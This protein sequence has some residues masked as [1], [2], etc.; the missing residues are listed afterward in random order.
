MERYPI[1]LNVPSLPN[2]RWSVPGWKTAFTELTPSF[3]ERNSVWTIRID[4]DWL[5]VA[6]TPPIAISPVYFRSFDETNIYGVIEYL[7]M[8]HEKVTTVRLHTVGSARR[9]LGRLSPKKYPPST[10]EDDWEVL[11][12]FVREGL[13]LN[14]RTAQSLI[15]AI[16]KECDWLLDPGWQWTDTGPALLRS[17]VGQLCGGF[18]DAD[19]DKVYR[20]MLLLL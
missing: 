12:W 18:S 6:Q 3:D 13:D 15:G 5:S 4:Y 8:V 11:R 7:A 16:K 14:S 19:A 9:S 10:K 17:R 1:P 20:W 2:P